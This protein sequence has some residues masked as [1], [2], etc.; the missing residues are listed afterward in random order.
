M[1][2]WVGCGRNDSSYQGTADAPA[3]ELGADLLPVALQADEGMRSTRKR[4]D[5]RAWTRPFR[6]GHHSHLHDLAGD[7][8][9]EFLEDPQV[10]G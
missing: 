1:A 7:T 2:G 10:Q 3:G 8:H 5:D 9:H 4:P 6:S